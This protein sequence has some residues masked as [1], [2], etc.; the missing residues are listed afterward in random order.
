MIKIA[1]S[2]ISIET[3]IVLIGN[4]LGIMV[5]EKL[6]MKKEKI[7]PK[8]MI[9]HFMKLMK[10]IVNMSF[11]ILKSVENKMEKYVKIMDFQLI[12]NLISSNTKGNK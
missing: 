12:I 7:Y 5:I 10:I 8:N 11:M 1:K 2:K 9:Y 6:H 3:Q 4:K